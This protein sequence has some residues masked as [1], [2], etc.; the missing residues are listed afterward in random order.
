[1]QKKL[2]SSERGMLN[3][4]QDSQDDQVSLDDVISGLDQVSNGLNSL[5]SKVL[6]NEQKVGILAENHGESVRY[7]R[8]FRENLKHLSNEY[9]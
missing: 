6:L 8:E 3:Q 9:A 4:L 2:Q 1:M 5:S 7:L